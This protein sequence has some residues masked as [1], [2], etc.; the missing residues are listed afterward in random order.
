MMV[1]N[2]D[3]LEFDIE[4]LKGIIKIAKIVK[5]HG[6]SA[7]KMLREMPQNERD[8]MLVALGSLLPMCRCNPHLNNFFWILNRLKEGWDEDKIISYYKHMVWGMEGREVS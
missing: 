8:W 7:Y 2:E 3:W 1:K 4:V 6:K 5:E